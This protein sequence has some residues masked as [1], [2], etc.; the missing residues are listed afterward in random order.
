MNRNGSWNLH[1]MA[2]Y[3]LYGQP[4]SVRRW[5]VHCLYNDQF[6][7]LHVAGRRFENGAIFETR[8]LPSDESVDTI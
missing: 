6:G 4:N 2:S 1:P 3:P 5:N 7:Y 8:Q